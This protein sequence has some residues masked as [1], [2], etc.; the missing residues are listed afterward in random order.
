MSISVSSI[1]SSAKT[2]CMLSWSN[3]WKSD[4]SLFQTVMRHSTTYIARRLLHYNLIRN[5]DRVLDFGCGPG[6]LTG[7]LKNLEITYDGIDIS[8]SFIKKARQS[9]TAQPMFRF[10]T[11]AGDN[12]CFQLQEDETLHTTYD[13][14]LI[15]SVIQYFDKAEKV[16]ALLSQCRKHLR[17]GGSIILSDVIE[18][19]GGLAGDLVAVAMNSLRHGYFLQFCRFAWQARFSRYNHLRKKHQLLQ[20]PES[21]LHEICRKL[22]LQCRIL[23]QLTLHKS[24]KN[25]LIQY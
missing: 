15:I 5:G 2:Y 13:V 23:P 20:L 7:I 1:F 3:Y 12:L 14:I 19:S 16:E 21:A 11:L 25:Y 22:T 24:R 10:H 9:F 17:K 8:E 18:N 4:P 6:Y